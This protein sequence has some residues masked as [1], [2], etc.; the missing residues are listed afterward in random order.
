M[1]LLERTYTPC[2]F[3]FLLSFPRHYWITLYFAGLRPE[4]EGYVLNLSTLPK[5][6]LLCFTL[7]IF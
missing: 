2:L 4:P 7:E 3:T 6:F 5:K 1:D